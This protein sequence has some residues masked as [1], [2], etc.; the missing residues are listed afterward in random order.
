MLTDKGIIRPGYGS[1]GKGI[2]NLQS[3]I[4]NSA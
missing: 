4:F 1:N 2:N 3:R